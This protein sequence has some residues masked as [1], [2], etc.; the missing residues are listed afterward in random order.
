M[1][2]TLCKEQIKS[3]IGKKV[4]VTKKDGTTVTGKL[5]Q[6]KGDTLTLTPLRSNKVQ[7]KAIL[8]LVLFDLLA[9]GTAPYAYGPYGAY[10]A[11]PKA[12]LPYSTVPI[13][14]YPGIGFW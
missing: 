4:Y 12:G 9:I 6:V 7:T 8:P 14:P 11:Y 1:V 13:L 10:G 5:R 3:L 2:P